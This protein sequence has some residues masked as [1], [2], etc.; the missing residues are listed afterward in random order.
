MHAENKEGGGK[1]GL[2]EQEKLVEDLEK[3]GLH[4]EDAQKILKVGG[5]TYCRHLRVITFACHT[6]NHYF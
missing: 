2:K 1:Q 4:K 3:S 5:H 6:H